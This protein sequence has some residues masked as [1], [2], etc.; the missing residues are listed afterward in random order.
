VMSQIKQHIIFALN[1]ICTDRAHLLSQA[2]LES[3]GSKGESLLLSLTDE[4]RNC[5]ALSHVQAETYFTA[6][7]LFCSTLPTSQLVYAK[8]FFENMQ[9][10]AYQILHRL[11]EDAEF[12]AMAHNYMADLVHLTEKPG[13]VQKKEAS[14][15][16]S[17]IID[18]DLF[19]GHLPK[20][21]ESFEPAYTALT[22]LHLLIYDEDD[23]LMKWLRKF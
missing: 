15:F 16:V 20:F 19:L 11:E 23:Q 12:V 3:V 17:S 18:L 1:N 8:Q 10:T 13:Q 5:E 9:E 6:I 21:C 2:F 14:T 4:L 22:L 7:S